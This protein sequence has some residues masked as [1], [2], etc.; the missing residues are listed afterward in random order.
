LGSLFDLTEGRVALIRKVRPEWQKGYL[1][2]IGGHVEAEEAPLEAMSREFYEE[3][4]V[5]V[6]D[7]QHFCTLK[8]ADHDGPAAVHF[9]TTNAPRDLKLTC[10]TDE[11]VLWVPEGSLWKPLPNLHWLI[12]M[13]RA[14]SHSPAGGGGLW[15]YVIEAQSWRCLK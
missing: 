1:N 12:A 9:F 3:T 2:G 8:T 7:W 15:P 14:G 4:G 13:A 6:R 10:M 11:E 5:R